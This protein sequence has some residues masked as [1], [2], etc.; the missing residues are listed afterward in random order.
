MFLLCRRDAPK[1]TSLGEA[2]K[3]LQHGF[4]GLLWLYTST[5]LPPQNTT[6]LKPLLVGIYSINVLLMFY[7]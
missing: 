3:S 7:T 2:S 1:S 6:H 4:L 5:D